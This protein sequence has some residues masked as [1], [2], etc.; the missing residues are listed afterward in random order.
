M[1]PII[2]VAI[3]F[4]IV[5]LAVIQTA[6]DP[7]PF[8]EQPTNY[9]NTGSGSGSGTQAPTVCPCTREYNPLCGS[10]WNTYANDCEMACAMSQD[11]SLCIIA[12]SACP[13]ASKLY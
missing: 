8:Y 10:D 1:K 6:A 13:Q 4:A 9:T 11:S 5:E 2:V 3:I 7:P 12:Y